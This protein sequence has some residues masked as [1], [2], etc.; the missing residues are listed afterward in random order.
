MLSA[1]QK[2]T[3]DI[4]APL[5]RESKGSAGLKDDVAVWSPGPGME[6]VI[7]TDMLVAGVHFNAADPPGLIGAKVLR[8]GLSDIAA[9]GAIPR[10]YF[11]ALA[12]GNLTDEAWLRAFADGLAADQREFGCHLAGG[13]TVRT[14]GP[15]TITVTTLGEVPAGHIVRRDGARPG[16]SIYVTGWIGD[17]AL[18]R[19]LDHRR[20]RWGTM[21]PA[22]DREYLLSRYRLP[23]PRVGTIDALR[24][25]ARA[26]MDISGGLAGDLDL[27]CWASGVAAQLEAM[28]V[29]LSDS[30][31][32]ALACDRRLMALCLSG[33]EDY[34]M[35]AAVPPE[36][37]RAFELDVRR[38]GVPVTRIGRFVEGREGEARVLGHYGAPLKLR[39]RSWTD[40][41]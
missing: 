19:E 28:R 2:I 7:S 39:R 3:Q 18:G 26:S 12:I 17:A 9:K 31:I 40:L 10:Y 21:L 35:L 1:A 24:S 11:L 13:D 29:P 33:G 4:F 34:E 14:P 5:S 36:A 22:S 16:D 25:H 23:Q 8:N 32:R 20:P 6:A 37:A 15:V 41:E 38:A 27:M 30:A